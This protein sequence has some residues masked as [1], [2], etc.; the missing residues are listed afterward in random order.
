MIY[1]NDIKHILKTSRHSQHKLCTS[2]HTHIIA[3]TD[4]H[5][6]TKRH[7]DRQ[8]D[9]RTDGETQPNVLPVIF[10]DGNKKKILYFLLKRDVPPTVHNAIHNR[11]NTTF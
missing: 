7:T 8:T 9:E 10:A 1:Y 3:W 2:R 6:Q 11:L 4:R 5:R